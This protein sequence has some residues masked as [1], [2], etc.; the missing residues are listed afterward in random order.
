MRS[1]DALF[2]SNPFWGII[3]LFFLAIGGWGKGDAVRALA[4]SI[5]WGAGVYA[6][7]GFWNSQ[8]AQDWR[9]FGSFLLVYTGVVLFLY[10]G[11]DPHRPVSRLI[12]GEPV[13]RGRFITEV[14]LLNVGALHIETPIPNPPDWRE[15]TTR[16]HLLFQDSPVLT[17][18]V[19]QQITEDLSAFREYLLSLGIAVPE[20]FPPIGVS[21]DPG[22][23]QSRAWG[24]LPTYRS[25]AR[26]NQGWVLDRR[27]ITEQYVDFVIAEM[28]RRRTEQHPASSGMQDMIAASAISRY[29]NCSFWDC[30][31]DNAGGYWSSQ[32]WEIRRVVG[33]QFTDRLVGFTLKSI[34]DNPE[35]GADPNFDV[36]FYRKIQVAD[37]VINNNAEKMGEIKAIIERLGIN[38][39]KPKV[40][41]E[42]V[43]TAV[44]RNDG[45][46]VVNVM[47]NN[48]TDMPTGK[49]QVRLYFAPDVRLLREPKGSEKDPSM[50]LESYRV[51]A[52]ELIAAHATS[53]IRLE[54]QPRLT[55]FNSDLI[56]HFDYTCEACARDSYSHDLKFKVKDL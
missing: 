7:Y 48:K 53:R 50:T 40:T 29:Y 13:G 51:F 42:F 49:G 30:K 16:M 4:L 52:F 19:R 18:T 15:P 31:A 11:I 56:I 27:A 38:V 23:A 41:L 6:F 37:S 54:L 32:L 47:V 46:F 10:Y 35:E 28:L 34:L 3:A 17:S 26:I 21:N 1:V 36:Y 25:G 24:S 39:T 33:K 44:K 45:S 22:S 5:A 9:L 2:N 14:S 12:D 43:S 55:S 8:T 20:E